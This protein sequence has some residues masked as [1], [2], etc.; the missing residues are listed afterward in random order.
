VADG[1][2]VGGLMATRHRRGHACFRPPRPC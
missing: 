2:R 1:V